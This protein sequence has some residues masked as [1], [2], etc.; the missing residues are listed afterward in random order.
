MKKMKKQS[1][2]EIKAASRT[3]AERHSFNTTELSA[4]KI[5]AVAE[6]KMDNRHDHLNKLFELK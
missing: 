5:K 1:T 6:T 4:E 3:D 2:S